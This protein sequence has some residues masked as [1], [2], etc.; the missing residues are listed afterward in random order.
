[1]HVMVHDSSTFSQPE[2]N[3]LTHHVPH[4]REHHR[5]KA[6]IFSLGRGRFFCASL[7]HK[8]LVLWWLN[9]L[10]FSG[11]A[12]SI[13]L[14]IFPRISWREEFGAG[15]APSVLCRTA[16]PDLMVDRLLLYSSSAVMRSPFSSADKALLMNL[17]NKQTLSSKNPS[18]Q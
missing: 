14:S 5:I 3:S 2:A 9:A 6:A 18:V 7:R 1:M 8:T 17:Y 11:I 4:H 13:H 16:R 12:T 15:A 10:V